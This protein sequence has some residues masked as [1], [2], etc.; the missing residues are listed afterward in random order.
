MDPCE[1]LC[2]FWQMEYLRHGLL[3][4][5]DRCATLYQWHHP[6]TT[7]VRLSNESLYAR[8]KARNVCSLGP[9][10]DDLLEDYAMIRRR[11]ARK[12]RPGATIVE[13][14][15]VGPLVLTLIIGCMEWCLYMFTLNQV[16]NAA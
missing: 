9:R 13:F 1:P 3:A 7:T 4:V 2:L 16:Q 10:S 6:V 14:A 5:H 15:L 11:I 12:R 8:R